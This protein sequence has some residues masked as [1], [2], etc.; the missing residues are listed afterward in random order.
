MLENTQYK[1]AIHVGY[2]KAASTTLQKHL[3]NKHSE[4]RNLGLYPT[5]NIG[6]DSQEIDYSCLYL[7][8]N[9]LQNFYRNLLSLNEA[10]SREKYKIVSS[11]LDSEKLNIFSHESFIGGL[12]KMTD[13]KKKANLL[14]TNFPQAKI[15]II[16]R[17]QFQLIESQ[18]RDHYFL[19]TEIR[20]GK[21]VSFK[22]EILNQELKQLI[23]QKYQW[24]FE[25]YYKN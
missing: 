16:I 25:N 17:N 5:Q 24:E 23:Y 15:V 8:D 7:K 22:E 19:P 3:F 18:Y 21:P 13:N 9:T 2:P 10:K 4:L 20:T 1:I 6:I 11:F 12:L 14:K